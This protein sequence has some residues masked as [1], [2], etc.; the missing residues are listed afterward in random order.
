MLDHLIHAALHKA[1]EI[2]EESEV[3]QKIED[4]I[5]N[6]L[7]NGIESVQNSMKRVGKTINQGAKAANEGVKAAI[8][9]YK[10]SK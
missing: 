5:D 7:N 2:F 1:V 6:A 4:S 8:K 10:N 9:T 3:G